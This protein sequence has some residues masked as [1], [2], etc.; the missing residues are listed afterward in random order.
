MNCLYNG[1]SIDLSGQ[2]NKALIIVLITANHDV[3]I[4]DVQQ[5]RVFNVSVDDTFGNG[6]NTR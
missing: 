3:D 1:T 6:A 5:M 4:G 2:F